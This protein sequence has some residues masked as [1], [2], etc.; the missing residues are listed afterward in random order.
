MAVG[1]NADNH[2]LHG[3]LIPQDTSNRE[4]S[5]MTIKKMILCILLSVLISVLLSVAITIPLSRTYNKQGFQED[6][7]ISNNSDG[8]SYFITIC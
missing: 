2:S 6:A 7:L 5:P 8:K 1:Y 3:A 4:K